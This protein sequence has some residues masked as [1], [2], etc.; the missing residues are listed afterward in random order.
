MNTEVSRFILKRNIN[1]MYNFQIQDLNGSIDLTGPAGISAAE[2][3][4]TGIDVDARVESERLSKDRH[5]SHRHPVKCTHLR[6]L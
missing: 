2:A 3:G 6:G 1:G 4:Q 5:G